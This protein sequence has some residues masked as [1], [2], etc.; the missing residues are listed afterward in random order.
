MFDD[1]EQVIVHLSQWA[2]SLAVGA[3]KKSPKTRETYLRNI[4][5]F[6]GWLRSHDVYKNLRADEALIAITQGGVKQYLS[7]L[8]SAG[9]STNTIRNR[10][11]TIKTFM[12]WLTTQDAGRAREKSTHDEGLLS[13]TPHTKSPIYLTEDQMIRY[14]FGF[15][16]EYQRCFAHL[17]YDVGYRRSELVRALKKDFTEIDNWPDSLGYAPLVVRG[18]KGKSGE[19]KERVSIISRPM[20]ARIKRYHSSL[21]YRKHEK[22]W[23][24]EDR[25]AFLNVHGEPL[26][27]SAIGHAMKEA[28]K[29][30]GMDVSPHDLRHGCAYNIMRSEHGKDLIDNLVLVKKQFG[31]SHI[32]STEKYTQIPALLLT[33]LG[34]SSGEKKWYEIADIIYKN[35]F[36]PAKAH[37]ENRG[38]K[39]GMK[40]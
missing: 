4:I 26:S 32:S 1:D 7:E 37:K 14:L 21:H 40:G 11:I 3:K 8:Q 5:Y 30:S 19:I 13:N 17:I 38:H 18:S 23:S 12:D 22:K 39:R 36:M 10:D 9:L 25:P 2:S 29:R 35:T 33:K 20:I 6:I 24:E 16:N 34:L 27:Y 28:S 31:H 15:H